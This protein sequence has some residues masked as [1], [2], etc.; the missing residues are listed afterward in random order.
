MQMLRSKLTDR[1]FPVIQAILKEHPQ[2]YESIKEA[3]LDHFHGDKNVDLYLKKLKKAKR[4][5]SEKKFIEGLDFKL[6]A[7]VKYK[8]FRDFNELVAATRVY[9]S[10]LEAFETDRGVC[11]TY[12]RLK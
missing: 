6:Q 1:T 7:K 11:L 9:A 8:E 10:R 4:K 12:S 2:Y 5:P 3:L